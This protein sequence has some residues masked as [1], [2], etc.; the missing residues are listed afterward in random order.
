MDGGFKIGNDNDSV[1][2]GPA[3]YIGIYEQSALT[4]ATWTNLTSASFASAVH[5]GN[6]PLPL[7]DGLL[8]LQI[9]V[10]VLGASPLYM[11]FCNVPGT[12]PTSAAGAMM[13]PG[14]TTTTVS[15][16][17]LLPNSSTTEKGVRSIS[18]RG[19]FPNSLDTACRLQAS[20]ATPY[21]G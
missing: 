15:V 10:M 6:T 4:N 11:V 5:G 19:D 13:F 21:G 8:C 7:T 1:A 14:N 12:G 20:F 3:Q 2:V 16:A 17:S 9:T 18:V